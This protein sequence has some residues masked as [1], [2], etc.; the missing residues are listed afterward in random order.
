[1]SY[2][3]DALKKAEKERGLTEI[4][5][6]ETVHDLPV[7]KKKGLWIAVGCG[8]LC[9]IAAIWLFFPAS[10]GQLESE[11]P[12][13]AVISPDF[14]TGDSDTP[15]ENMEP[16]AQSSM[17]PVSGDAA[18]NVPVQT[19]AAAPVSAVSNAEFQS[20]A[21]QPEISAANE[22]APTP[23]VAAIAVET[24]Q[25]SP[26]RPANLLSL[27][28][29]AE[30]MKIG[31]H[32]YSD[33]PDRRIVFINGVRR[34]EGASLEHNC[35]LESITPEGVTLRRGEETYTIQLRR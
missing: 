29:I 20:V 1:M 23:P 21:A 24:M 27:R 28:E 13:L 34:T 25:K 10:S 32:V 3:L 8:A 11:P 22:K 7:K 17:T 30:S 15:A 19:T 35:V 12:A 31:M 16:A 26:P 18:L 2:I 5:T 14:E 6:I 9:L 33:N 4:P